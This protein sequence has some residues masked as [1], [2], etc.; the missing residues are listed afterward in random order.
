MASGDHGYNKRVKNPEEC[1]SGMRLPPVAPG[2]VSVPPSKSHV[3]RALMLSAASGRSL[4]LRYAHG[5]SWDEAGEDIQRGVECAEALGAEVET[6]GASM[7]VRPRAAVPLGGAL[8]VGESGFLGRVAPAC[9][10]LCRPGDWG[11]EARGSLKKR[12]SRALWS[13]LRGAG[14]EVLDDEGWPKGVRR[15]GPLGP[16]HLM[17]ASSSQEL[18]ALWLG[19]AAAGGGEVMVSGEV[20]SAP[21]LE[22]TRDVLSLF[23]S[24]VEERAGGFAVTSAS[25]EP[26]G[27]VEAE[28]D[29]S[30]AAVALAA[31]CLSGARVSVPGPHPDS[32]QGDWRIVHYL[33]QFGCVI[34]EEGDRLVASEGPTHGVNLDLSGEPDLAPVLAAVA[35]HVAAKS[36]EGSTFCGLHT[37]DGKESRRGQVLCRGLNQGGWSS[38]W[39]D[40]I[41][42]VEAPKAEV[43]PQV[44]DSAGD[45]RMAFAFALLGVSAPGVSVGDPECIAKSWPNFWSSMSSAAS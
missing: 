2:L 16:L 21:Y 41:L 20:P 17:G 39:R 25:Q 11:I 43:T 10:A 5:A 36:G 19:L 42:V 15:E 24:E 4:E 28:V 12:A 34:E 1:R 6:Q 35:A 32:A 9:A 33:R 29:A 38:D 8:S 14:V 37:L 44:L 7:R 31:G 27:A 45:H 26:Q 22:L 18:S 3:L 30:A 40:P 13:A 23:G